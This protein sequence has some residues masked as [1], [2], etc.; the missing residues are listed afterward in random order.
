ME[1]QGIAMVYCIQKYRHYSLGSHFKL[2][3]NHYFLKHLINNPTLGDIIFHWLYLFQEYDFE[4][5]VKLGKQM[6]D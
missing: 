6:L 2:Y 4:V 1:R 3:T 5:N